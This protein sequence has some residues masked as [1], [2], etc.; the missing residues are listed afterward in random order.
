MI[1][2]K[3]RKTNRTGWA[4]SS[5]RRHKPYSQRQPC[6]GQ[7]MLCLLCKLASCGDLSYVDRFW[8]VWLSIVLP[9]VLCVPYKTSFSVH[10]ALVYNRS[11]HCFL[12]RFSNSTL[13]L[14]AHR[15]PLH[16][17]ASAAVLPLFGKRSGVE[18]FKRN[19]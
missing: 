12:H 3:T 9:I 18:Q 4:G 16:T 6:A 5:G 10:V 17:S 8:R 14:G 11:I 19:K 7:L 13:W 1:Q 15:S 2:K